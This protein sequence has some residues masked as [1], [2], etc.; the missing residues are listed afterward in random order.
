MVRRCKVA[1]APFLLSCPAVITLGIRA[2][3]E[4]YS[5][6]ERKLLI[7]AERI[8]FPTPRFVDIL[9]ALEKPSFPSATTYRYQR[10][11]VLQQLLFQ[12]LKWPHPETRIY[13]GM[14]QKMRISKEFEFPLS[15]MGPRVASG[16][17][18]SVDSPTDLDA[19]AERYNPLIVQKEI[20]WTDRIRLL[21]VNFECIGVHR[22]R[23]SSET[24]EISYEPASLKCSEL[25][26][27]LDRTQQLLRMARL[28][29]IVIEWGY[30]DGKW[31]LLG[32]ERPPVQWNTPEGTLN[33]HGYICGRIQTG[34]L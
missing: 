17:I 29:D 2:A 33:R 12:Y 23:N 3:M 28:D 19:Y 8:F 6:E 13:F 22:R 20:S 32:M 14:K 16:T 21:C 7:Q 31:Q 9:L 26:D 1:L 10:S 4:D 25:N 15:I 24:G 5:D 27:L 18:H 11:R 34:F 30:G